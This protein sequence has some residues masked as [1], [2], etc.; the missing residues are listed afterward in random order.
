MSNLGSI[1]ALRSSYCLLM[2]AFCDLKLKQIFLMPLFMKASILWM[3][4][5]NS[6]HRLAYDTTTIAHCM[7]SV[8]FSQI[9]LSNNIIK[10]SLCNLL[11][12]TKASLEWFQNRLATA[13]DHWIQFFLFFFFLLVLYSSPLFSI[14]IPYIRRCINWITCE[15]KKKKKAEY[16]TLARLHCHLSCKKQKV[17]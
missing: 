15:A 12:Y 3:F 6:L 2:D 5:P 13:I 8:V 11:K 1:F 16:W 4:K 9:M 17:I 14:G 7:F 10:L